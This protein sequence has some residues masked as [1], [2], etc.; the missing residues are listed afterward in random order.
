[1]GITVVAGASL[2]RLFSDNRHLVLWAAAAVGTHLVAAVARRRLASAGWGAAVSVI[3]LIALIGWGALGETTWFGLP[4]W[5]TFST[6][7]DLMADAWFR[8]G[9]EV[10]P[11]PGSEGFVIAGAMAIWVAG[12]LADAFAFRA[13]TRFEALVPSFT[14]VLFGAVL[15]TGIGARGTALGYMAAVLIFLAASE[16]RF[17]WRMASQPGYSADS[18]SRF[19]QMTRSFGQSRWPGAAVVGGGALILASL[20]GPALAGAT[21]EPAW[22]QRGSAAAERTT[23]SPLVDIRSRLLDQSNQALFTVRASRAAYWRLTSLDSFDGTLW[24][25]RGSYRAIDQVLPDGPGQPAASSSDESDSGRPG[26]DRV[27]QE[28]EI[29][30]LDS[31][32]LPAAFRPVRIGAVTAG[33][34][35][36]PARLRTTF[37]PD[38]ASLV[39]DRPTVIGARYQVESH[40]ASLTAASLSRG[41][42]ASFPGRDRYLALPADIDPRVRQ[43]AA[44]LVRGKPAGYAQARALQDFFRSG[45]RYSL[46]VPPGHGTDAMVRFLFETRTGYCEQFAGTYAALARM[47]G[48]P[49]RVAVGFTPGSAAADGVATVRGTNAHAWPEVFLAPHGWVPFEPTPGRAVPGG[50]A[51]TGIDDRAA[52]DPTAEFDPTDPPGADSEAPGDEIPGPV[53]PEAETGSPQDPNQDPDP[54]VSDGE[55]GTGPEPGQSEGR[56]TDQ[57]A[58]GAPPGWMWV[59]AVIPAGGLAVAGAKEARHRRRR[60][61]A[62]EPSQRVVLA[63]TEAVEA[64][65]AAGLV[66]VTAGDTPLEMSRRA[67]DALSRP[68]QV[69]SMASSQDLAGLSRLADAATEARWRPGEPSAEA[70]ARA[71]ETSGRLRALAWQQAGRWRQMWW[72]ADPRGLLV[73]LELPS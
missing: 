19:S 73:P 16:P 21:G 22:R 63:W 7:W 13:R 6:G 42:A 44:D 20:T 36:D 9:R 40:T 25:S 26:P 27:M 47:V 14:L 72:W 60:S 50:E 10:A 32:W 69:E 4:T 48:L 29:A 3:G 43:L 23:V 15:G 67:A 18:G 24:S 54:A 28:V 52:A 39:T 31:I 30:G 70:V 49:A 17:W 8:F 59:L 51:Y 12:A 62:T 65:A 11:T 1:M 46:D 35:G 58:A 45:F 37:D 41:S 66:G 55:G 64:F 71:Q 57:E 2:G 56:G 68:R 61:R 38:S 53:E 33:P 34:R 5:A